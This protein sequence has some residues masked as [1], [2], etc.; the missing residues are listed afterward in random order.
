MSEVAGTQ[1]LVFK[2]RSW[3]PASTPGNITPASFFKNCFEKGVR[4]DVLTCKV[5]VK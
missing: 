4:R 2:M 3:G 5:T 1:G